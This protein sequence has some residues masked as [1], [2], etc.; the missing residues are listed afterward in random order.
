MH[1][2]QCVGAIGGPAEIDSAFLQYR[3]EDDYQYRLALLLA[4]VCHRH[5]KATVLPADV[6]DAAKTLC[7]PM[8]SGKS[9]V[10]G[11]QGLL[12]VLRFGPQKI[13]RGLV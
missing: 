2:E 3:E 1:L 8:Y 13:F 6:L 9:V 11:G 10:L 4:A 7:G 5:R 12:R